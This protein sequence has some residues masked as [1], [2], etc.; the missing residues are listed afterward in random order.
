MIETRELAK[1][2]SKRIG[3]ENLCGEIVYEIVKELEGR[4]T[5]KMIM[6]EVMEEAWKAWSLESL[7]ETLQSN[8]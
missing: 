1:L 3:N 8:R 6:E 5:A 7:W 2:A 4:S